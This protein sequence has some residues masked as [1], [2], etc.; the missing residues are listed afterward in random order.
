MLLEEEHE[1]DDDIGLRYVGQT[2]LQG[3]GLG[4]ELRRRVHAQG[5]ARNLPL[6]G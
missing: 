2:T 3:R 4:R 1:G 5:Q 6:Q